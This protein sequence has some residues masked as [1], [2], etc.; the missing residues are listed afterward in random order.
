MKITPAASPRTIALT[1]PSTLPPFQR[2]WLKPFLIQNKTD[3]YKCQSVCSFHV[4]L[5][6]SFTVTLNNYSALPPHTIYL[7][8]QDPQ[9]FRHL[10]N[11]LKILDGMVTEVERLSET[12]EGSG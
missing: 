5:H 11:G 2:L 10:M 1:T 3:C 9:P 6:P 12:H 7:R 4:L 8:V